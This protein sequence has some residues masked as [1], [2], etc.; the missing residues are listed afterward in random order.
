M[1]TGLAFRAFLSFVLVV[2]LVAGITVHR[3]IFV[4]VVLMAVFTRGLRVLVAKCIAGFVVIVPDVLPLLIRVAIGTGFS[5]A[6]FVL[7]VLLVTAVTGC[8]GIPEFGLR[9]V[10]G[11]A[12]N[13]L[14]VGMGASKNKI[15]L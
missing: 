8:R 5:R 6:P 15:G 7:V 12:F 10:A 3:R 11:F 14:A 1:V 4:P 13:L 9:L 2:F